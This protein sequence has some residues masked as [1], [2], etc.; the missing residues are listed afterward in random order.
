ME[1]LG[2]RYVCKLPTNGIEVGDEVFLTDTEVANANAGESE[3]RFVLA[4]DQTADS[5]RQNGK[6]A[7][8]VD[9]D[10]HETGATALD[11]TTTDT[12]NAG[13]DGQVAQ[14]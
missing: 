13:P 10:V 4:E 9:T 1:E 3:P 6:S 8:V 2:K 11:T 12:G 5:T 7:A 14:Q